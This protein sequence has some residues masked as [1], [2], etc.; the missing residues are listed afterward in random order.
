MN[1]VHRRKNKTVLKHMKMCS[2]FITLEEMQIKI[3]M[4]HIF[5]LSDWQR[6]KIG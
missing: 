1:R 4:K 5:F 3:T 2:T 6:A